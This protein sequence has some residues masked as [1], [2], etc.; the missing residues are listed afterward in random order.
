MSILLAFMKYLSSTISNQKKIIKKIMHTTFN[1]TFSLI[2]N[3][4]EVIS[5]IKSIV[6]NAPFFERERTA[7]LL[8]VLVTVLAG[9][10][11]FIARPLAARI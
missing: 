7:K 3:F 2:M 1:N 11:W 8:A 6:P 9:R 5:M 10:R 4:F